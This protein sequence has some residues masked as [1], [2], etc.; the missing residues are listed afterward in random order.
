MSNSKKNLNKELLAH[1]SG[2]S[3][4]VTVP[5]LYIKIAKGQRRGT[6]L[7][8]CIFWSNKSECEDGWFYKT[9]EEWDDEICIPE[10]T[11]RRYFERLEN[12]G[13]IE[14]K[15]KKIRGL[16]VKHVRPNMDKVFDEITNLLNKNHPNRPLCP[17]PNIEQKLDKKPCTKITPTGQNDRLEPATLSGSSIY[18]EEYL[19]KNKTNNKKPVFVFSDKQAV[20]DHLT[21]IITK[22][23]AFIEDS[24]IDEIL[25]YIGE[26]RDM[27]SVNKKINI[28]LKKIRERKWNIPNGFNGITNESI[29]QNDLQVEEEKKK[30]YQQEAK[31]FRELSEV[32]Q[33]DSSKPYIKL[34]DRVAQYT[35][36]FNRRSL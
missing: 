20:K 19:Q 31:A 21:D 14:T 3:S 11:L 27:N 5:K 1:F 15:I 29:R 25:F 24:T 34:A 8:Q 23:Q 26:D 35:E 10:R 22:R 36:S 13:F 17:D 16:N 6:V 33:V 30:Q 32:S 18:T 2:Q 12:L 28:A 9:Y 4:I 7:N